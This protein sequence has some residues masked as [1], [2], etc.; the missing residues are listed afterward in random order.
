M[1]PPA[2]LRDAHAVRP[3]RPA[4]MHPILRSTLLG[5]FLG[6]V[7]VAGA[8]GLLV[9]AGLVPEA[10]FVD[11]WQRVFGGGWVPAAVLG[12]AA[13]LAI[14]TLWG[15]PFTLV[16]DPSVPAAMAYAALPTMWALV[17][18]PALI[19]R[20]TFAGGDPSDIM[21][22]VLMTVGVWGGVLGGYAQRRTTIAGR[23]A[24]KRRRRA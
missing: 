9:A 4:A 23:A 15:V 5:A 14:G 11:A 1:R 10:P 19:G 3:V 20:P 7:A 22:T 12:T 17:G 16:P 8:Y 24:S 21:M 2:T 18:W 13:F 6:S